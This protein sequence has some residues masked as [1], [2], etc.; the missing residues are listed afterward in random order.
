M[1][2][3]SITT[4]PGALKVATLIAWATFAFGTF[5]P[6]SLAQT[7]DSLE[8]GAA[9]PVK[10]FERGQAAHARG[11]LVRA[12]EL[13][14]E[15]IKVR[16]EFPEAAF[17]RGA[18]QVNLGK[19]IDAEAS[20]R[21]AIELRGNWSFP[22]SALG[23]LLVRTNRE[24]DAI[25]LLQQALKLDSRDNVALRLLADVRLRAG[26]ANG[27]LKLAETAT[28]D[29]DAPASAWLLR[30]MAERATGNREAARASL[31]Q[32]L[33]IE[34]T[35][36]GVLLERAELC[37]ANNDY[38]CAI[39]SLRAAERIK[40]GDKN[41]LS[42]LAVVYE[43]AGK[44]AEA[45][46]ISQSAGLQSDQAGPGDAKGIIGTAEEIEAA[47]SE[48]PAKARK[49]LEKLLQKNPKSAMLLARL[50]ASYRIDSPDRSV[51]FYRRA[52]DLQPDNPEYAT[53]Y[54]SALIR[55][56][57][58]AE[59]A[60]VLRR[61]VTAVPDHYTAHANLATALYQLKSYPEALSEYEWLLKTRPSLSIAYYFIATA[62]DYLGEYKEALSAYETFLGK[63]DSATNQLEIEKVKLRI[64]SLRRQIQI[65]QGVKRKP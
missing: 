47:N 49:A 34:P 54:A 37:L 32:A 62:H 51:D 52:S 35:H 53:G 61:I 22:Y 23:A 9:D 14:D 38:D 18:V 12:L 26:D 48:E 57:R 19:L 5:A 50:G 41:I 33:Q 58:Y 4:T 64:P 30:A 2:G 31:D 24:T 65:G 56:R 59:A 28:S 55:S 40:I 46:R 44:P 15:A 36:T 8:D 13:Y 39:D 45:Q 20:F 63:A 43:R 1:H 17:Q 10:L 25:P 29:S 16:P 3:L 42:R 11:D 60:T 21:Q 27:A 7:E 6:T